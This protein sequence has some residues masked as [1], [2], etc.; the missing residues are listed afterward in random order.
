MSVLIMTKMNTTHAV[1]F[2]AVDIK[3]QHTQITQIIRKMLSCSLTK[4]CSLSD[5]LGNTFDCTSPYIKHCSASSKAFT[6]TSVSHYSTFSFCGNVKI[7]PILSMK[8]T[9][10]LRVIA[11]HI[12][13]FNFFRFAFDRTYK[14]CGPDELYIKDHSMKNTH[15][16]CGFRIP[17]SMLSTGRKCD[18]V[19]KV[20][21]GST[22]SMTLFYHAV[23][24][25]HIVRVMI[26]D[27]RFLLDRPLV[28]TFLYQAIAHIY[29]ISSLPHNVIQLSVIWRRTEGVHSII[30]F[31]GPGSRSLIIMSL[32]HDTDGGV[33]NTTTS[34]YSM[35]ILVEHTTNTHNAPILKMKTSNA[36]QNNI[37]KSPRKGKHTSNLFHLL[38]LRSRSTN[39]NFVCRYKS[40]GSPGLPYPKVY[41]TELVFF[42]ADTVHNEGCSYGGIFIYLLKGNSTYIDT[43][44]CESLTRFTW[45]PDDENIEIFVVWY[46]GYSHGSLKGIIGYNICPTTRLVDNTLMSYFDEGAACHC[47]VCY[48]TSC[49][50]MLKRP[51]KSFGPSRFEIDRRLHLINILNKLH[52]I[53]NMSYRCES[54]VTTWSRDFQYWSFYKSTNIYVFKSQMTSHRVEYNYLHNITAFVATCLKVPVVMKLTRHQCGQATGLLPDTLATLIS[55]YQPCGSRE[56]STTTFYHSKPI[57]VEIVLFVK[58][59]RVCDP[60][61]AMK[62]IIIHEVMPDE[63]MVYKY[64]FSFVSQFEWHTHRNQGGFSFIIHPQ[65]K[66]CHK[67]CLIYQVTELVRNTSSIYKHRGHVYK[68]FPLG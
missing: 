64:N 13:R 33:F 49:N 42:G 68:L 28:K 15:V 22:S 48:A 1:H 46:L 37:C 5:H 18:I 12:I 25:P 65:N 3:M 8:A 61:C 51:G 47:Y 27:V 26:V 58:R 35:S 19:I 59:P 21:S 52:V 53:E 36:L 7:L 20:L 38:S 32:N 55:L 66:K 43:A 67:P 6:M 4:M 34:A 62:T 44:M 41:L 57:G 29:T 30:V 24:K 31:D 45:Y 54:K 63:S 9:L 11:K 23:Y 39:D 10:Y 40:T 17:W 2:T 14:L 16:Y 60:L 50:V 56:F